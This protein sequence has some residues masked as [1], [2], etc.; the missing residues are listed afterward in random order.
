MSNLNELPE[1]RYDPDTE[2]MYRKHGEGWVELGCSECDWTREYPANT[3][4]V[5]TI[6]E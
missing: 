5:L 6:D 2:T 1:F 4:P 3:V